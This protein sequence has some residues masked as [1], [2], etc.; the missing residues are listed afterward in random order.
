[1]PQLDVQRLVE[2]ASAATA[3]AVA[4]DLLEPRRAHAIWRDARRR[5]PHLRAL[6]AT[7]PEPLVAPTNN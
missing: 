4:L 1:M 5:Q 6:Q 2:L 3:H 7:L